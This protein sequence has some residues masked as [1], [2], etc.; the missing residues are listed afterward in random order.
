MRH[1]IVFDVNETLLDV[2]ALSPWFEEMFGDRGFHEGMVFVALFHS[3]GRHPG[4]PLSTSERWQAQ[5]WT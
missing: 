5:L 4:W 3:P 2:R 1:T